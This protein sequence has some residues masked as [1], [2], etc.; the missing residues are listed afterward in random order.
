V[1]SARVTW[2]N[3]CG[4]FSQ[5]VSWLCAVAGNIKV[6]YMPAYM[7]DNVL[8]RKILLF[9]P[10]NMTQTTSYNSHLHG[11]IIHTR[12][13]IHNLRSGVSFYFL[14]RK[15][16]QFLFLCVEIFNLRALN[17]WRMTNMNVFTI[18]MKRIIKCTNGVK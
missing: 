12:P 1:S 14:H 6:I 17:K 18:K 10:A 9:I 13:E 4:N 8:W 15:T 2:N 16:L 11:N 3:I 7:T 5:Y